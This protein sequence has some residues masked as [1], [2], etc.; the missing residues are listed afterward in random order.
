MSVIKEVL[1]HADIRSTMR[2]AHV[3][4]EEISEAVSRLDLVLP[5]IKIR[6]KYE[7]R[8]TGITKNSQKLAT[9]EKIG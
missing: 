7:G 1:G 8:N 2:Y 6:G 9:N 4:D 3:F 5:R